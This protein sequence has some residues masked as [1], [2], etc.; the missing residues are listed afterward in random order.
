[1]TARNDLA[2]LEQGGLQQLHGVEAAVVE[3]DCYYLT[4]CVRSILPQSSQ[5]FTDPGGC[6]W[7]TIQLDRNKFKRLTGGGQGEVNRS[8]EPLI[9]QVMKL[10]CF[11]RVVGLLDLSLCKPNVLVLIPHAQGVLHDKERVGREAVF[12][13]HFHQGRNNSDLSPSRT[14]LLRGSKPSRCKNRN[15]RHDRLSPR[16]PLALRDAESLHEPTTIIDGVSHVTSP[17]SSLAIVFGGHA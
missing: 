1:M 6:R 3:R 2:V 8:N 10:D 13:I 17:L 16:C 7:R 15:H 14:T 9:G 4:L 5:P 11:E 12:G